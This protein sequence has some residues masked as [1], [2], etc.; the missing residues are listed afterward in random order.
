MAGAARTEE[1]SEGRARR[2]TVPRADQAVWEPPPHRPDPVA[3]IEGQNRTRLADLVPVRVSRMAESPF[4]FL[5]G[6]A[7]VMAHDLAATADT[8]FTVQVCGDAHVANFG[9]FASPERNLLFDVNDFDETDVGP[10]EWDVKRLCASAAVVA[11]QSGH[12]LDE[13]REAAR[14]AA[15]SYRGHMAEYAA[16][17]EL[18]LWYAR[19]DA[20]AASKILS[21]AGTAARAEV[22]A[23]VRAARRHTARAA[24]PK[25][26]ALAPGGSRRIV[27]HPPLVSHDGVDDEL[28]RTVTSGYL[29]T[30]AEDRRALAGRFEI[31]D[32]AR[33]VVGVGSVGTRCFIALLMDELG[34]PLLLQVKEADT[35]SLAAVGAVTPVPGRHAGPSGEGWRVVDGQR[36]MQAASDVFLG[37]ASA[38]GVDFYLRQLRD[39]KGSIDA[40]TLAPAALADYAEL[41]GWVL[42]RAHARSAGGATAARIAGY[43]GTS[44]T[45]DDAVARFALS[46]ADQ[47]ERDYAAFTAA[48]TSGR[49][50]SERTA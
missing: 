13:Q 41:C 17:G 19:V 8:G 46:Y 30:L 26:T 43:L 11:R 10:W 7:L 14:A 23:D 32:S 36:R 4:A 48:V 35:S 24:L 40:A 5:R 20:Q 45:F 34:L 21:S 49:L 6:A 37:W 16:M 18:D 1:L 33:K 50:P 28:V 15:A 31:L 39:M 12:K 47:N 22:H 42:A 2:H 38:G 9:L 29:E 27:D 3:V 44:A 25:L